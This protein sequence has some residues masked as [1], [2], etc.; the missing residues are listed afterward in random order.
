[1]AFGLT[2]GEGTYED[3]QTFRNSLSLSTMEKSTVRKL[4]SQLKKNS[5]QLSQLFSTR[6]ESFR[7]LEK[8]PDRYEQLKS[9]DLRLCSR[10]LSDRVSYANLI[11][12]YKAESA[13]S[14]GVETLLT[15]ANGRLVN[16]KLSVPNKNAFVSGIPWTLAIYK[17]TFSGD[18]VKESDFLR[19][20]PPKIE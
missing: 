4:Q 16:P 15:E 2:D 11:K 18:F 5:E 8:T 12:Y 7:T 9:T 20:S 10:A 14:S 6:Y 19:L 13:G 1:L 17:K 3:M